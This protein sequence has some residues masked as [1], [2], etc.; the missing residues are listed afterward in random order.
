[1][2]RCL[3]GFRMTAQLRRQALLMGLAVVLL[4]YALP[5]H[6]ATYRPGAAV[7]VFNNLSTYSGYLLGRRA[8]DQLALDLGATGQWRVVD[9]ARTDEACQQRELRPPYAVAY[10]QAVGHALGTE[11]IFTGTVQ[12]VEIDPVR[13]GVKVT[14]LVEAFD[15]ISGQ[16]ILATLASG[17]ARANEEQA[18]P[19]DI[20]VN[21]ALARACNEAAKAA[22]PVNTISGAVAD[23]RDSL[24]ATV[25]LPAGTTTPTGL[26]FLIYRA[27]N[28]GQ[29]T[30]AGKLI[31]TAMVTRSTTGSCEVQILGRASELH[32][33]D[34]AYSL[35]LAG[36]RR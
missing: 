22:E 33:G 36:Q 15:Q 8:A 6:A 26:R 5:G 24:T 34:L 31:A 19:T 25:K 21:Y 17:E 9:R 11:V 35:S 16:S 29:E 4:G 13:G 30:S 2:N 14:I 27:V 32:T 7:L 23:P 28:E 3:S 18:V 12:K 20:V 10:M 1:V